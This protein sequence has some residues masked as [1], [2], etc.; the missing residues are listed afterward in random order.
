MG[1][2]MM[3]VASYGRHGVLGPFR[4]TE[5]EPAWRARENE[6]AQAQRAGLLG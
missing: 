1:M 2:E 5:D 6:R 3:R 4:A